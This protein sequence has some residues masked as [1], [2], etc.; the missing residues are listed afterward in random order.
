MCV[1]AWGGGGGVCTCVRACVCV[2]VGIGVSVCVC[3]GVGELC[4][5]FT[6]GVGITVFVGVCALFWL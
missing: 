1:R 4:D 5:I 6:T 2:C 3:L